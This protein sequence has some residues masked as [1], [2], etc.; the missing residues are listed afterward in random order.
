MYFNYVCSQKLPKLSWCAITKKGNGCIDL[1]HGKAVEVGDKFFVEGAWDSTFENGN[2]AASTC[3]MGS[4]G[5]LFENQV[6]FCTP[7][8]T[9]DYLYLVHADNVL[10][11]SNSLAFVLCKSGL[12]LDSKYIPYQTDLSSIK[13]GLNKYAR[14][15]PTTNKRVDIKLY[16]YCNFTVDSDLCVQEQQKH[17]MP[18]FRNFSEYETYL[19]SSVKN[20][21]DNASAN[22]RSIKYRLLTTCSNGYDSACAAAIGRDVGCEKVVTFENS[23]GVHSYYGKETYKYIDDSGEKVARQLGYTDIRVHKREEYLKLKGMPEA[24][25]CAVGD[26]GGELA[27]TVFEDDFQRKLVLSGFDGDLVW[28]CNIKKKDIGPHIKGYDMSGSSLSEFRLRVG[29]IHLPVP[30]LG[31]TRHSSI[32][33]ISCSSE[34]VPWRLRNSYDRSIPRRI[35]EQRGVERQ[36]FG[37]EKKAVQVLLRGSL[38]N[39]LSKMTPSA[40]ASFKKYYEE[41]RK[42]RDFLTSCY[43]RLMTGIYL[44]PHVFNWFCSKLKLQLRLPGDEFLHKF[45]R[46][47][48]AA[49][50]LLQWGFENIK[51]RYDCVVHKDGAKIK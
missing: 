51:D 41:E 33:E 5:Q 13:L 9:L 19:V 24:E 27:W 16:G 21:A 43:Y 45:S 32:H 36:L 28:D 44:I 12:E 23:R 35:V 15:I 4:G 46:S 26:Y 48:E 11:V 42:K 39:L 3:L 1:Y 10:Y 34:M 30:F 2:L 20:I 38:K 37:Q 7:C 31:V 6:Q 50:F 14:S 18:S 47:P 25:F 49:S 22:G 8:H 17:I 29:F 40:A